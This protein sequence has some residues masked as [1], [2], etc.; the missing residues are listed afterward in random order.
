MDSANNNIAVNQLYHKTDDEF[1]GSNITLNDH[2]HYIVLG[3]DHV[4]QS[5]G[6][7]L[8]KSD[9]SKT[10][11]VLQ[12]NQCDQIFELKDEPD[13][14]GLTISNKFAE[15]AHQLKYK[16][17][18]PFSNGQR[19]GVAYKNRTAKLD[20][21][22][23]TL[24]AVDPNLKL[25]TG[26]RIVRLLYNHA[27]AT[28]LG[29]EI[30]LYGSR[31][32]IY[33]EEDMII[34]GRCL[35]DYQH[36]AV[37]SIV[38]NAT[39]TSVLKAMSLDTSLGSPMMAPILY[40][41]SKEKLR[42]NPILLATELFLKSPES[43]GDDAMKPDVKLRVLMGNSVGG[44][45]AWVGFV[46]SIL[47]DDPNYSPSHEETVKVLAFALKTATEIIS[48]DAFKFLNLTLFDQ[49]MDECAKYIESEQYWICYVHNKLK[50]FEKTSAFK[51][52]AT[53]LLDDDLRLN[54]VKGLRVIPFGL[55][56][57]LLNRQWSK[58][59][60]TT[61]LRFNSSTNGIEPKTK[62]AETEVQPVTLK[63]STPVHALVGMLTELSK[64]FFDRQ[65]MQK[66]LTD[67]SKLSNLRFD[68]G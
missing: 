46:P 68:F 25:L 42:R 15:C 24:F 28:V 30:E 48:C 21:V 3:S 31:Q 50:R 45:Y 66:Q 52:H 37:S 63:T 19:I 64:R 18:D 62:T 2:Y 5:A 67:I 32:Y 41:I 23:Q 7:Y 38:S 54:G 60:S 9:L 11:L 17:I 8:A 39:L 4:A 22:R 61:E 59:F 35:N 55:S 14:L 26:A 12:T 44:Q 43:S 65:L 47:S 40:T 10:V 53:T 20:N 51:K 33:A 29:V 27:S 6:F 49:A 58:L 1:F 36:L 16:F 57:P 34:A 13:P 56:T